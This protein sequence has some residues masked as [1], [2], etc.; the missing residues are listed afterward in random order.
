MQVTN[1]LKAEFADQPDIC[2]LSHL[3]RP[4]PSLIQRDLAL[5][6]PC[7]RVRIFRI[8]LWFKEPEWPGPLEHQV[9]AHKRLADVAMSSAF[10]RPR[11]SIHDHLT[12]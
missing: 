10:D 12:L 1:C 7:L 2:T 6:A 5:T 8:V 3:I 9:R 11:I 4:I